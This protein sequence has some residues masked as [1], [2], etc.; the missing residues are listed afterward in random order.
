MVYGK[1]DEASEET[2]VYAQVVPSLDN[3]KEKFGKTQITS[4]EVF[5]IID[6]EVKAV[7][8]NMPLY[9]RITAAIPSSIRI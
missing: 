1:D 5:R 3:I 7:N 9:K 6:A 4:D 8:K 2:F